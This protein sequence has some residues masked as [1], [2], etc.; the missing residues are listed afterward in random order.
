MGDG[1]SKCGQSA[2]Y[3]MTAIDILAKHLGIKYIGLED[4]SFM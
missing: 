2:G 4:N 1:H 3:T